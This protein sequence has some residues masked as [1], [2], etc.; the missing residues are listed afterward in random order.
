M[1]VCQFWRDIAKATP[2]LWTC[3][4]IGY[5]HQFA[6]PTGLWQWLERSGECPLDV[7]LNIPLGVTDMRP[8]LVLLRGHVRR[9]HVLNIEV[10]TPGI[11]DTILSSIALSEGKCNG[12]TA[13]LLEELC[14]TIDEITRTI[15]NTP[16]ILPHGFGD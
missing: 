4:H 14:I 16:F 10:P 1:R 6:D 13:P 11:A 8:T 2:Q 12:N 7:I 5:P 15:L 3:L 9:F